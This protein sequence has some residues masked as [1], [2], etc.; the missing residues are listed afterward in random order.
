MIASAGG[1]DGYEFGEIQSWADGTKR[2]PIRKNGGSWVFYELSPDGKSASYDG[3]VW[4]LGDDGKWISKNGDKIVTAVKQ[5]DPA[6]LA[7]ENMISLMISVGVDEASIKSYRD[8][9]GLKSAKV[10]GVVGQYSDGGTNKLFYTPTKR[11]FDVDS[12]EV[13]ALVE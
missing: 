10:I 4:I 9:L 12:G 8:A 13:K 5:G 1:I 6:K 3:E 7:A 11:A 2:L